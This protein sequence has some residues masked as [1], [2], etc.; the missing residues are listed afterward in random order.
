MKLKKKLFVHFQ[1]SKKFRKLKLKKEKNLWNQMFQ[2]QESSQLFMDM[3]KKIN[4]FQIKININQVKVKNQVLIL[5]N[6]KKSYY[7]LIK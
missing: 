3:R 1:R 4:K 6:K 2:Y 5:L 7:L